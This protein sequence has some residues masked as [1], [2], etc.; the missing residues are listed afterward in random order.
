MRKF[1]L[2]FIA[3]LTVA[4]PAVALPSLKPAVSVT[5]PVVTVGDL[6][7]DAGDFASTPLFRAPAPGTTG[8]VGIAE[9]TAAAAMAGLRDFDGNGLAAVSVGRAG[10]AFDL[11][12]VT[13]LIADELKAR[14][15]MDDLIQL[16]VMPDGDF[17]RLYAETGATEPV[18]LNDLRIAPSSDHFA[19][20]FLLAGHSAPLN[21]T[22]RLSLMVEAP[23][24]VSNLNA[25]A[26]LSPADIEMRL[27]PAQR[28][29]SAAPLALSDIV[30]MQMRRAIRAGVMIGASD[31]TAPTLVARNDIV[32][33]VYRAGPMVLT[34]RGSA[35][36][37]GALGQ[38]VQV[39]NLSSRK[40]ID[41]VITGQGTVD[42]ASSVLQ[43][44]AAN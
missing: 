4:S 30:G 32:T 25:G 17:A 22:G 19:A 27:V 5:G 1:A 43:L 11:Q 12:L 7:M 29:G 24:L 13:A 16:T 8:T 35:L 39:L 37:E 15:A 20:Q 36:G 34:A 41:G 40:V 33:L 44:A 9:I 10:I 2:A 18:R 38:S 42:V 14:G 31:L 26:V 6:F 23:H 21:L 3:S 28:F